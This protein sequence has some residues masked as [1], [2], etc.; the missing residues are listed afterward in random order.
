MHLRL[1]LVQLNCHS[2]KKKTLKPVLKVVKREKR[3]QPQKTAASKALLPIQSFSI[4]C[5]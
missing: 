5:K 3:N 1:S 4:S 2:G